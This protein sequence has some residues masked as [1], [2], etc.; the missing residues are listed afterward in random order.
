MGLRAVQRLG[1]GRLG[2]LVGIREASTAG[3]PGLRG[4]SIAKSV[5]FVFVILNATIGHAILA[6]TLTSAKGSLHQGA[7]VPFQAKP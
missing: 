4:P 3:T 2:F 7:L 5:L 1:P 6:T